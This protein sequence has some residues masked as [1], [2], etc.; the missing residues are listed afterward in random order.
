MSS[1][2]S[3]QD[4]HHANIIT[5]SAAAAATPPASIDQTYS[6]DR[7]DCSSSSTTADDHHDEAP[8]FALNDDDDHHRHADDGVTSFLLGSSGKLV[9]TSASSILSVPP[10]RP[11]PPPQQ[12]HPS[13]QDQ[14][15]KNSTG[16]LFCGLTVNNNE[17]NDSSSSPHKSGSDHTA[18]TSPLSPPG[19]VESTMTD[20]SQSAQSSSSTTA[21]NDHHNH[22]QERP[23]RAGPLSSTF[24]MSS[25]H[26][27]NTDAGDISLAPSTGTGGGGQN[28]SNM[29]ET[30]TSSRYHP[31][32]PPSIVRGLSPSMFSSSSLLSSNL[33]QSPP[34]RYAGNPTGPAAPMIQ[35]PN[36][37]VESSTSSVGFSQLLEEA[38]NTYNHTQPPSSKSVV[39][40]AST[41]IMMPPVP[42]DRPSTSETNNGRRDHHQQAENKRSIS[43]ANCSKDELGTPLLSST[44]TIIPAAPEE[45]DDENINRT[46]THVTRLL[47]NNSNGNNGNAPRVY[48]PLDR[49]KTSVQ[50]YVHNDEF[51]E[52][53]MMFDDTS[54]SHSISVDDVMKIVANPDLLRLWCD[55]IETL[56]VTSSSSSM[57]EG[58]S[59]VSSASSHA[60][61]PQRINDRGGGLESGDVENSNGN[62]S[63]SPDRPVSAREYEGEWIEAT[64]TAL[65]SPPSSGVGG[66]MYQVGQSMMESLGFASYGRITMFVERKRGH[67]SLTIGPFYGGIYATHSVRVLNESGNNL[68]TNRVRVVDRVRLKRSGDNDGDLGIGGLFGCGVFESCL[69]QCVLPS[70]DGYVEQVRTSL[71]RLRL[72]VESGAMINVDQTTSILIVHKR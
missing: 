24:L 4:I 27:I 50:V 7:T 48:S 46:A 5:S 15:T 6:S 3:Y 45:D 55:P 40:T 38:D 47:S 65:D 60:A 37:A 57:T 69:S 30:V 44:A 8:P 58:T 59:S 2:S 70:V 1:S 49:A 26:T 61:L 63:S 9:Q 10:P 19:L 66:Y 35:Q 22:Q 12:Q 28:G 16:S 71:G 17:N 31:H 23:S 33:L 68:G 54:L 14:L 72:L 42:E 20:G 52:V 13:S 51:F 29:S 34:T 21:A 67:V 64:T 18:E 56:I 36:P 53:S 32:S 39:M 25:L 41:T 62:T 43:F 11:P